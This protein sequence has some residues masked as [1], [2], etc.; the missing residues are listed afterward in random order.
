MKTSTLLLVTLIACCFADP[1]KTIVLKKD[2]KQ[3]EP[4]LQNQHDFIA[5]V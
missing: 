5:E 2:A 4:S 3:G 1:I